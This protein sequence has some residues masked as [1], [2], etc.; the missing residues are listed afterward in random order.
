MDRPFRDRAPARGT[1]RRVDTFVS[2]LSSPQSPPPP[3]PGIA[4]QPYRYSRRVVPLLCDNRAE[5][6]P[7]VVGDP[8]SQT[9][10]P[11]SADGEVAAFLTSVSFCRIHPD[12]IGCTHEYICGRGR[13]LSIPAAGMDCLSTPPR[14]YLPCLAAACTPDPQHGSQR[15]LARGRWTGGSSAIACEGKKERKKNAPDISLRPRAGRLHPGM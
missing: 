1:K 5:A 4:E 7:P 15:S 14:L 9:L 10:L 6:P 12:I 2:L 8:N 11:K 13:E 3:S